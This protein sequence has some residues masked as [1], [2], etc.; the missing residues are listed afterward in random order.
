MQNREPAGSSKGGQFAPDVKQAVAIELTSLTDEEYEA[1][2][3]QFGISFKT[4]AYEWRDA[5]FNL[6]EAIRWREQHFHCAGAMEWRRRGL[7][8][9]EEVLEW[10]VA[11][12]V[13]Y[14][15]EGCAS[16]RLRDTQ[17]W[18][19]RGFK[20]KEA[21]QWYS[22]FFATADQAAEWRDAGFTVEEAAEWRRTKH[23]V[24]SA[25]RLRAEE[26]TPRSE[27]QQDHP[28]VV[29]LRRMITSRKRW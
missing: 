2:W 13:G 26:K 22:H 12:F 1:Q 24:T 23:G 19:D 10:M 4:N 16:R 3:Q 21:Q 14:D 11:G 29:G 27:N 9:P 28:K 18:K 17:Q 25:T 6:D 7:F 5:G 8:S 20:P 15:R